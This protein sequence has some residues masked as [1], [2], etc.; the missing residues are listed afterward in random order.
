M[1]STKNSTSRPLPVGLLLVAEI[2][3][4]G[5]SGERDA[6]TVAGRLVHLAVDHG[7]LGVAEIVLV[8]DARLDHLVIEIVAL[9]GA[10]TD[11]GEHRQTAVLLGDVVDE[12][13][14]VDGLAHAGAAEQTH[15]AAL[16]EGTSKSMTLMPV[17]RRSWPPACSS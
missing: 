7:H 16:R 9:A 12:L 6:Q 15:L 10:L 11:A 13:E 14:H 2:F 8:D 4:H 17:T 1:L 3:R 5:E